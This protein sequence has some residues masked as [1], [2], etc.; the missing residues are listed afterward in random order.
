MLEAYFLDIGIWFI[1]WYML[2]AYLG[3]IGLYLWYM[4]YGMIET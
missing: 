2:Q 1:V 4:V 3:D